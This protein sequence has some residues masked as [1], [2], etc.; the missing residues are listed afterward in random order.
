MIISENFSW[1]F[2]DLL[3]LQRKPSQPD[4][5]YLYFF[6]SS[7]IKPTTLNTNEQETIGSMVADPAVCVVSMPSKY[8]HVISSLD[9]EK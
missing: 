7:I 5:D 8:Q 2:D 6:K 9:S 3:L 4:N 1:L